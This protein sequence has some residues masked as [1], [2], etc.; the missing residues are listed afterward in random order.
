MFY[1][2]RAITMVETM[3]DFHDNYVSTKSS[4][5]TTPDNELIRWLVSRLISPAGAGL[6]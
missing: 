6:L 4:V 2:I 1:N 3:R 5:E